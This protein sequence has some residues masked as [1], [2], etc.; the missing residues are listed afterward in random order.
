MERAAETK[1]E[2][3]NGVVY[4]MSGASFAHNFIVGGLVAALHSHLPSRC[5]VAPSDLKVRITNPTRFYYPDVTVICGAAQAADNHADILLNPL[6]IFEVLSEK[7]AGFDRGRKFLSY[8]EID[9]LQEYVLVS[10]DEYLVE[11]YRRDGDHWLYAAVSGRE[12]NLSLPAVGCELPLAEVYD[13]VDIDAA[14]R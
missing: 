14:A 5:R 3:D 7:T 13:Q 12:S 4:A 9:S 6:I 1:S 2:Y 11:H 8:Q 10:Q